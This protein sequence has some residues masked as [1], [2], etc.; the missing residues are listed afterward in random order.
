MEV[1]QRKQRITG[2]EAVQD[3]DERVLSQRLLFIYDMALSKRRG[4]TY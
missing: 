3:L 4:G 2:K 1:L